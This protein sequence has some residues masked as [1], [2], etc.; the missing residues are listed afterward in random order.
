MTGPWAPASLS[1]TYAVRGLSPGCSRFHSSAATAS[2]ASSFH[3]VTDQVS[4]WT[5]HSSARSRCASLIHGK[6]TPEA[7]SWTRGPSP[8]AGRHVVDALEDALDVDV[9]R[10]GRLRDRL[11]V[12]GHV[13]D[14]VLRVLA[15]HPLEA[16]LHD[17]ADLVGERRVVVHDRRVGRREQRRVAVGVLQ[18]L[19]GERGATGGG[20]D[21]EAARELVGHRPDRVAGALEPEHRVEDVERDHV[22]AVRGVRRARGG[23]R[24]HRAGLGDALVEHLA[25][26]RLLV[27]EQHIAVDR[28]VLL[29]GRV[30]DLR[31]REH[32]VHAE[33]AV[34]VRRDRH[35]ALADLGVLHPVLEQPDDGHGGGDR[36]LAASPS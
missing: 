4:A 25:L 30:V 35:E 17:V 31:A 14:D 2:R 3:E 22:L 5:P 20:A 1:L 12:D 24:G 6:P 26:R 36:V 15:V 10:L 21:Q 33:G 28:L 23:R 34:L 16:G 8:S 29:P 7:S 27:G 11:V 32:R 19:T 9:L 18:A 13:E